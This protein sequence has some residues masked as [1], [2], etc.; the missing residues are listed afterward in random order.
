MPSYAVN[1]ACPCTCLSRP[2]VDGED[3]ENDV[4][5]VSMEEATA[6]DDA[7]DGVAVGATASTESVANMEDFLDDDE[8]AAWEAEREEDA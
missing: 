3:D 4:E 6:V 1:Y 2:Q 8:I 7:S 5:G